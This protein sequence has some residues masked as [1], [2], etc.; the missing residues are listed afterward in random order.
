MHVGG[1]GTPMVLLHGATSSWRA[2]RPV[3]P[4]LER[5]HH[6]VAPTL[7]GHHG[8]PVLS[9]A[10]EKVVPAIVDAVEVA[11]D[12]AGIDRAHLVGNSLGG[13]VA[14]EL[15]R[16]GRSRSVVALSPAGA[17]ASPADL[18]RLLRLFRVGGRIGRLPGTGAVLRP[19]AVRR[20]LLRAVS[21]HPEVLSQAD[22]GELVEDLAG[23]AVLAD[24]LAGAPDSGGLAPFT[25]EGPVMIAWGERDRILPFPRYGRPMVEAVRGAQL[26]RV[27][28]VGH[29]PMADAPALVSSLI[30]RFTARVDR[31]AVPA[32][33][34]R[35]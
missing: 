11:L 7:A 12:E 34:G 2:W 35:P 19:R 25:P 23:C 14:L 18:D 22:V 13:W 30:T 5:H 27:P 24:L 28:G 32:E 8:G 3:L 15:A 26:V 17:W 1:A 10:P 4:A 9:V 20:L 16:R 31:D 29:V 6:V 21:E 33:H